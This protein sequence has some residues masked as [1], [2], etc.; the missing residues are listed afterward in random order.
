ML[1]NPDYPWLKIQVKKISDYI[2]PEYYD[3]ILKDYIFG[4]KSDL[5]IFQEYL[6]RGSSPTSELDILEIGCGSGRSSLVAL[7]FFNRFESFDLVDLSNEMISLARIKLGNGKLNFLLDDSIAFLSGCNKKYDLVFSLWN[8]SHSVHQRM[9]DYGEEGTIKFVA[10][11]VQ[12]FCRNNLKKNGRFFI[13]HFDSMSNEQII[14]AKQ[15]YK[16]FSIFR[17]I[18][19][20]SPSK[21]LLD[22]AFI[23]LHK[24][25]VINLKITHYFGDPIEYGSLSEVLEVFMNFH[26]ETEF[27]Q[28]KDVSY[29]LDELST[30]FQPYEKNGKYFITPGCFVY[31]I[32]RK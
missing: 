5:E 2:P 25:G 11:S 15:K 18:D 14:L 20:Q 31:E 7:N 29:I 8:L 16:Y 19:A 3:S 4:G 21:Q 23:D 9:I 17:N 30:D 32:E 10:D 26:F 6:V 28:H 27:N 12:K 22:H 24:N 1:G 13:I